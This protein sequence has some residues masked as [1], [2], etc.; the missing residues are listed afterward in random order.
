MKIKT[1]IIALAVLAALALPA[2]AG[3]IPM[4]LGTN[5][6]AGSSATNF[7][8]IPALV[9]VNSTDIVLQ[10]SSTSPSANTANVTWMFN[11]SVDNTI[12]QTNALSFTYAAT[13][14]TVTG[15]CTNLPASQRFPF[16]QLS[17]VTNA[18]ASVVITNLNAKLFTKNGI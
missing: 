2:R 6:V 13:G 8:T 14:A 12:W 4:A 1:L 15:I 16:Y 18:S 10:L 5:T 9:A 17:Y 3:L 7:T 11:V